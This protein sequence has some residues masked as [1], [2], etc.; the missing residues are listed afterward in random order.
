MYTWADTLGG[1]L[2][3]EFHVESNVSAQGQEK[4]RGK[5]SVRW[6]VEKGVYVCGLRDEYDLLAF[7]FCHF[8]PSAQMIT[9]A[10]T[11]VFSPENNGG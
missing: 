3:Q 9:D 4:R 7:C 5:R 8:K 10:D 1:Q 11:N 6:C 2:D